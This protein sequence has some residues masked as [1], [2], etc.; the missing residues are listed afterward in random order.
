MKQKRA[1]KIECKTKETA[2]K[3]ELNLDGSG[4]TNIKSGIGFLDHMLDLW[5]FHGMFD[6]KLKCDGDLEIDTHHT[7]EDI[8]L[9]L[10]RALAEAV[11]EKKGIFRYGHSYVPMD[12]SLIRAALDLSGRPEFVFHGEFTQ[13]T[14]GYL[15]TQM[16]THFFKSL[17][18]SARMT[19]HLSILYGINDHHKCEGMFKSVGRALRAAVEL[20]LRRKDVVST[21]GTL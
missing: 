8:A 6:L 9:A 14:I 5:A 17:A 1:A 4:K 3:L 18:V 11:G 7:T 13:P 19:L 10:G 15:D 20:D 2:I 12:E 21:K 16:I